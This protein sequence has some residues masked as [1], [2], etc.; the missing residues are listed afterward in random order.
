VPQCA[1]SAINLKLPPD[2]QPLAG[3]LLGR[4]F[5]AAC[6]TRSLHVCRTRQS[7]SGTA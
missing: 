4:R 6:R 2:A 7:R 5:S 1:Q 3:C